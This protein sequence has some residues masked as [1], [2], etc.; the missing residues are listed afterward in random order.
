MERDDGLVDYLGR[1]RADDVYAEKLVVARLAHDLDEALL[2]A[3]YARLARSGERKLRGLHVV[4]QLLRLR[5]GESDRR[6]FRIAVC[7]RRHVAQIYRMSF[8]SRNLLD[9]EDSLF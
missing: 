5:F 4:A 9:D 2:F 3:E 8:L 1:V 6:D 7:A